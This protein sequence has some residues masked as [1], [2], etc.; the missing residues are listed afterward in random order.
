MIRLT[1]SC[2]PL[3]LQN[4]SREQ[5]LHSGQI[6]FQQNDNS[7]AVFFL[8]KGQIRLVNFIGDQ[9]VNNYF[10]KPGESF[11]ESAPFHDTY[12]C[13]AIADQP[14]E[15]IAVPKKIFLE[16]LHQ[17]F[18][19]CK[20][21]MRQLVYRFDSTQKVLTLRSIRSARERVLQYLNLHCEPTQMTVELDRPLKDIA[22]ELGMVPEVL[23]RTLTKLKKDGVIKRD[24][25]RIY[26][27]KSYFIVNDEK[28]AS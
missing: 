8:Q 27:S 28:L 10:V 16:T 9:V 21:F 14:S 23:S 12:L 26:L 13:T 18:D 22:S 25:K 15:V 11:A 3:T 17:D 24:K 1:L 5:S 2:L 20:S 7:E 6:L 19:V 4:A